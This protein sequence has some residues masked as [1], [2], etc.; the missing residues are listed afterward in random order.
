MTSYEEFLMAVEHVKGGKGRRTWS[1]SDG[2]AVTTPKRLSELEIAEELLLRIGDELRRIDETSAL[3]DGDGVTVCVALW[4]N[5]LATQIEFVRSTHNDETS[6]QSQ[7]AQG[8][9]AVPS[10]GVVGCLDCRNRESIIAAMNQDAL[11]RAGRIAQLEKALRTAQHFIGNGC[12][13]PPMLGPWRDR[14]LDD[15]EK[16]LTAN[17]ALTGGEAVPSNGVVGSLDSGKE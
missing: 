10:N 13:L 3:P 15:I 2:W 11:R 12:A 14:V 6:N 17:A 4:A 8:G 9:E 16:A 1:C 5:E 7:P